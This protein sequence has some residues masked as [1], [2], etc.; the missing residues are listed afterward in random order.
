V[1]S[2]VGILG[3]CRKMEKNAGKDGFAVGGGLQ[4][5][6][7]TAKGSKNSNQPGA[8]GKKGFHPATGPTKKSQP[9]WKMDPPGS[10]QSRKPPIWEKKVHW[11]PPG[12]GGKEKRDQKKPPPKLKVCKT[13]KLDGGRCEIEGCGKTSREKSER[14]RGCQRQKTPRRIETNPA[15]RGR[16]PQFVG[17]STAP[18]GSSIGNSQFAGRRLSI[19]PG[20]RR[21]IIDQTQKKGRKAFETEDLINQICVKQS[22]C[23]LGRGRTWAWGTPRVG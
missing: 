21:K 6:A 16:A 10:R 20:P 22:N 5:K 18:D 13:S 15:D 3:P 14:K 11:G 12:K 17:P 19:Q 4:A 9:V 7:T 8:G 23:H 2:G 1:G